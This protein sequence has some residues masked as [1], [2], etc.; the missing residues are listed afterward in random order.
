[1]ILQAELDGRMSNTATVAVDPGM[2]RT[3]VVLR[4]P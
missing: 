4:I 1:M 2:M 3:G